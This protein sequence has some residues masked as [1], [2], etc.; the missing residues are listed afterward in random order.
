MLTFV[1][2]VLLGYAGLCAFMY[3]AQDGLVFFPQ[4]ADSG[5]SRQMAPFARTVEMPER[6]SPS[7]PSISI[8]TV[9]QRSC[10]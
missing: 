4:L 5:A 8:A 6:I 10:S 7:Q 2:V 3:F 9:R 1:S